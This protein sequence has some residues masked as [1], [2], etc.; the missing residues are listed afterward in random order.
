MAPHFGRRASAKSQVVPRPVTFRAAFESYFEMKEQQLSNP[1]HA[2][3]WRSTLE[4]YVLPAI[5][6]TP[7]ASVT[8]AQ[9]IDILKLVW[10]D[11]P[12]T[13]KRVLQRM[14]VVFEAAIVRGD[15]LAAAPTTGVSTVL[16]QRKRSSQHHHAAL[17]YTQVPAFVARLRSLPARL[18][19]RL[20]F[21]FLILTATRSGEV[22]LASYAEMNEADRTWTIPA[23]R[24]KAREAHVIPLSSRALEILALLGDAR[25]PAD[26]LFPGRNLGQPMSDMTLTK[27][28]R[29][30]GLAGQATAHGFRSSFKDWCAERMKV[31]DEVSEA[32]L[33][34]TI[35]DKVRAAY[36]R[37]RFLDERRDLMQAWSNYVTQ[38][39]SVLGSGGVIMKKKRVKLA[40]ISVVMARSRSSRAR[41]PTGKARSCASPG[42]GTLRKW[43]SPRSLGP[44]FGTSTTICSPNCAT[45][46]LHYAAMGSAST[47]QDPEP[48]MIVILKSMGGKSSVRTA[49]VEVLFLWPVERLPEAELPTWLDKPIVDNKLPSMAERKFGAELSAAFRASADWLIAQGQA[50]RDSAG[51]VTPKANTLDTLNQRSWATLGRRLEGELDLVYRPM[52]EGVRITGRHTREVALPAGRI[53]VIQDRTSFTLIPWRPE[54]AQMRGKEIDVAMLNRTLTLAISRGRDRGLS[55]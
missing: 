9:V 7:V 34:H 38:K 26:L 20:A 4:A 24:M 8:P 31:R 46:R 22:R 17:P 42:S 50:Y 21:E 53:A 43:G 19:T 44:A 52:T 30:A 41:V 6:A 2:G 49:R 27:L 1:K 16:G 25:P 5:G 29:D 55:R 15:R 32:A 45:Y 48:G 36:L 13:A 10:T 40:S 47:Q 28:L 51:R 18:S 11:K 3:Q 12:E 33:A 23:Q 54:L 35:P 14:R 37:T 39:C